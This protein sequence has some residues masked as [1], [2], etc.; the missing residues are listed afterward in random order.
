MM[1]VKDR[2]KYQAVYY[3]YVRSVRSKGYHRFT[4]NGSKHVGVRGQL[5]CNITNIDLSL[6]TT[7]GENGLTHCKNR[8]TFTLTFNLFF[9]GQDV[10]SF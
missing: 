2:W 7:H 4:A 8:M 6:G 10:Y 1:T 3:F 9:Y 5:S